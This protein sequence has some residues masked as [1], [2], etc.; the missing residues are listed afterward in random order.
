MR[1]ERKRAITGDFSH[2][3][4]RDATAIA[5]I[6]DRRSGAD[7]AHDPALILYTSLS[8]AMNTQILNYP[9]KRR[10]FFLAIFVLLNSTTSTPIKSVVINYTKKSCIQN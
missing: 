6:A 3:L 2:V 4:T 1:R 7:S 8:C 9:Q 10:V 5:W